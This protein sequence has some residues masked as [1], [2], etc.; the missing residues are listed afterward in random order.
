MLSVLS[1]P[2]VCCVYIC[3]V[4]MKIETKCFS[5]ARSN[6]HGATTPTRMLGL[7]STSCSGRL[8]T[9]CV[10]HTNNCSPFSQERWLWQKNGCGENLSNGLP[11]H[12]SQ[13]FLFFFISK[14][15][16]EFSFL[17]WKLK[18]LQQCFPPSKYSKI[19]LLVLT[20]AFR[21]CFFPVR[22]DTL[23]KLF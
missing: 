11:K 1:D 3:D 8:G 19:C 15:F 18:L 17:V 14:T 9:Q 10:V 22:A 23:T 13:L 12:Y 21:T 20:I 2:W 4:L 6:P 7:V 16:F 5:S